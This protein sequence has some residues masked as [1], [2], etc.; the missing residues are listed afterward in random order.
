MH[1]IWCPYLSHHVSQQVNMLNKQVVRKSLQQ[2][3]GKKIRPTLHAITSIIRHPIPHSFRY[4]VG[5]NSDSVFRHN[6][7]PPSISKADH[8]VQWRYQPSSIRCNTLSLLHPTP[9]RL[10]R[11]TAPS[12]GINPTPHVFVIRR[13]RP[14]FNPLHVTVFERIDVTIINVI[15]VITVIANHML[16]KPTLPQ[17]AFTA[18]DTHL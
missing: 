2:V 5:R 7:N 13:V 10:T 17:T 18:C 12:R 8:T 4:F 16:P 9:L 6:N 3:N 15:R 11:Y 1:S 14:I